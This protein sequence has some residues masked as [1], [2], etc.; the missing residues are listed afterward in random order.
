MISKRG[1]I[2]VVGE[3]AFDDNSED[4]IDHSELFS[5][6]GE[7]YFFKVFFLKFL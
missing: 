2:R 3:D 4:G 7:I 5:M 6:I 1:T